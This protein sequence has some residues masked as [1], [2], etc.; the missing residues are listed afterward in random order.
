MVNFRSGTK[1]SNEVFCSP[2]EVKVVNGNFEEAFKRFK[3]LVQAE[4]VLAKYKEHQTYEKPSVKERRKSR[5]ATER[6]LLTEAREA[7]MASGEWEKKQKRKEQKRLEKIE[8]RK[9][10]QQA[11]DVK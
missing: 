2:L 11:S 10:A 1:E 9:K 4:G 5:E 7:Q 8:A 3:N 6:R